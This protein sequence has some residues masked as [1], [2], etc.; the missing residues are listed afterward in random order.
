MLVQD[1]QHI[2][3]W[4]K[5][6]YSK[7]EY[8]DDILRRLEHINIIDLATKILFNGGKLIKDIKS[9]ISAWKSQDYKNFGLDIGDFLYFA[10]L[11]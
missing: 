2:L 11:E 10:L 6:C 4:I 9:A 1:V 8:I 7:S 5:P 3:N